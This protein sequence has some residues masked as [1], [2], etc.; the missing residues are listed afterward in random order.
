MTLQDLIGVYTGSRRSRREIGSNQL[1]K[2]V[3]RQSRWELVAI[4]F[5]FYVQIHVAIDKHMACN[6]LLIP[7]TCVVSCYQISSRIFPLLNKN[8]FGQIKLDGKS[9]LI[10][11]KQTWVQLKR[12]AERHKKGTKLEYSCWLCSICKVVHE[13]LS[14]I[15]QEIVL[16]PRVIPLMVQLRSLDFQPTTFVDKW[17]SV[18]IYRELLS[19]FHIQQKYFHPLPH[20]YICSLGTLYP[21]LLYHKGI[22]SVTLLG[23]FFSATSIT[24][25]LKRSTF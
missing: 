17:V 2:K 21:H 6:L 19:T 12:T 20:T 13:N 14:K 23:N 7:V 24:F 5:L 10:Q 18:N 25:L 4:V 3:C 9:N 8:I 1:L 15:R 16:R 11:D 22:S